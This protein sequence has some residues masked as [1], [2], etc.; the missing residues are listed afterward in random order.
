MSKPKRLHPI[1]SVLSAGKGLK[2]LLFPLIALI[3]SGGSEG[4]ISLLIT[5]AISLVAVII[6]LII[7]VISWLRYTYRFEEDELRIEYGVF[8]RQ[9]R[10]IPFERIQSINLTEGL[11]QQMFGLVKVQIETAGGGEEAEAVLSAVSKDDAKLIQQYVTVAKTGE[12]HEL[13]DEP[14]GQIVFSISVPEL[15]ILSLTSGGVGVVISAA[16]AFLSQLD[17]FIPYKKIFGDLE[18]WA[19]HNII[20]LAFLVFI[21]FFL[22]WV[23]SLAVT[24]LK[25]ANFNVIKTEKDLIISQGLLEK[26]QITI[27]LKRIQAIRISENIIRQM[28]GYATVSIVSAGG[29]TANE[30]E[31]KVI[32]LPIV[33]VKEIASLLK[34]PLPDYQLEPALSSAPKR[35]RRRYIL[36]IWYIVL[37]IV[38]AAIFF[39]QT[40]GFFSLII[41]VVGTWWAILKYNDAGW[42]LEQQQLCLRSRTINRTTVFMPRKRIQSLKLRESYFQQRQGLGTLEA[43]VKSGAGDSWIAV[44]DLERSDIQ[45]V[46]QWYS[47][48]RQRELSS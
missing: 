2:K 36:R 12:N 38:A 33:R 21:G 37:P 19:V 25:Y 43:F 32:L 29:S 4:K 5:L 28:L 26:K 45:K 13:K 10:Y 7:G 18:K 6:S 1:A 46:Y 40:W 11:L 42:S 30:E 31:S 34:E 24:M 47:R 27:P 39:F 8:V 48:E 41:L 44:V 20:A 17:D 35:A 22:A 23:I 9:K 14:E 16:I 15:M 3:I